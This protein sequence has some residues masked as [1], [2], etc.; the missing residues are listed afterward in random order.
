MRAIP[1]L[2]EQ[3]IQPDSWGQARIQHRSIGNNR[4]QTCPDVGIAT[5]LR[6]TQRAGVPAQIGQMFG[7]GVS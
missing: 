1:K 4:F 6:A 5:F 3:A 7:D 2:M